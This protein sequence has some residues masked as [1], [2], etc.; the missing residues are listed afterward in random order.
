M[1]DN[2]EI[3]NLLNAILKNQLDTNNRLDSIESDVASVKTDISSVQTDI[4]SMKTEQKRHGDMLTQ[5]IDIGG[6]TSTKVSDVDTKLDKVG[7]DVD[8]ISNWLDKYDEDMEY[9]KGKISEH[10]S[11]IT[12]VKRIK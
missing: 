2:N 1:S 4:S 3:K 11:F 9:T 6:K 8:H 12:Q 7:D 5:L 10:D